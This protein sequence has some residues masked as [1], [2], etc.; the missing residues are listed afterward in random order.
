MRFRDTGITAAVLVLLGLALTLEAA[1][2]SPATIARGRAL[3]EAKCARCHAIGIDDERPHDIVTPFR[4]FHTRFPIDMLVD[5]QATGAISGH[6]EMPM[7]ELSQSDVNA[8]LT[9]IDSFA[10]AERRYLKP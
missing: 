6:D 9:Y 8:L 3:A 1:A 4:D 10:P 5:A 2:Q 7:F